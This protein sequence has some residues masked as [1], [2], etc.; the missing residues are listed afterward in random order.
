MFNRTRAR[1][2]DMH[3]I[4]DL[5]ERA[6]THAREDHQDTPGAEHFLL[7]ALDLPDGTARRA[8][9]AVGTAP[10]GLGPAIQR[11]YSEA[12]QF[13]GVSDAPAGPGETD[14]PPAR[15]GP[16]SAAPSG[17]EVMLA[18][19]ANRADHGP[20]LGAHVVAVVA[21][22]KHGVA[23]RA[24]RA[25][26]VDPQALKRAAEDIARHAGRNGAETPL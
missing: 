24:L 15:S 7:S 6:E 12:L 2:A 1:L 17:Q 18:L 23:A 4:K 25:M 16:F 13:I 14:M 3:T 11:Q 9:E 10:S 20:L 21:G 22:M 19:A 8:F 26:G 5:C